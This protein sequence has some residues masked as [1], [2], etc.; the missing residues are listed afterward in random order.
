MITVLTVRTN[1]LLDSPNGAGNAIANGGTYAANDNS[2][3]WSVRGELLLEGNWGQFDQFTSVE[4][5]TAGTLLGLAYWDTGSG[6]LP[7]VPNGQS[8]WIVDGQMQFDGSNLYAAYST[9]STDGVPADPNSLTVAYGI[10]LDANWEAYA[11]Y[12][13]IDPDVAGQID[14]E[15]YTVGINYYLAGNNAKWSLDYSWADEG[16]NANAQLG[17]QG[18]TALQDED[19]LRM[20]LQFAF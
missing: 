2:H 15:I 4:G 5:N 16:V 12:Q 13:S 11:R 10:Y 20:Q 6:D 1:G 17:W 7:L 19:M 14:S 8:G 3:S 9:T 18:A